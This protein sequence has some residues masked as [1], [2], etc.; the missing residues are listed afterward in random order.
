MDWVRVLC[1]LFLGGEAGRGEFRG[2]GSLG[3]GWASSIYSGG[4]TGRRIAAI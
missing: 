1:L 2:I 3:F 4:I